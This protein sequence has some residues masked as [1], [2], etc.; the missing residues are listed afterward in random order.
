MVVTD[1]EWERATK[2]YRNNNTL[3]TWCIYFDGS[4]DSTVKTS[5]PESRSLKFKN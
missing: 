1:M 4:G 2:I 5:V 3:D